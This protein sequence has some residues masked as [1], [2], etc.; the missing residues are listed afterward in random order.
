MKNWPGP[1]CKYNLNFAENEF[2]TLITSYY[3]KLIDSLTESLISFQAC[4]LLFDLE[5]S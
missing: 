3:R 2:Y 1:P 4:L 5:K